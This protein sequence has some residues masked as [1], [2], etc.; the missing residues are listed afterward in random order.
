MKIED[1]KVGQK[2]RIRLKPNESEGEAPVGD[3]FGTVRQV[4]DCGPY[5]IT[6]TEHNFHT[7]PETN[8]WYAGAKWPLVFRAE[9][10]E[11]LS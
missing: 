4:A 10:V 3:F 7:L 5:P 2:V 11:M 1:I 8:T 9:E 6:V